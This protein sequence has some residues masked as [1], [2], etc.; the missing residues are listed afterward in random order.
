MAS[1]TKVI[2]TLNKHFVYRSDISKYY[3]VDY[4]LG[5]QSFREDVR[6]WEGDCEDYS[7]Y[8]YHNIENIKLWYCLLNNQG[9][10][11]SELPDGKWIDNNTKKPVDKLNSKQYSNFNQLSDKYIKDRLENDA[12]IDVDIQPIG[13]Y[14]LLNAIKNIPVKLWLE[15]KNIF[16]KIKSLFM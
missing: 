10:M 7:L 6:Y 8:L 16:N 1:Y 9:H 3:V 13:E 2:D 4:W 11:V 15:F 12:K 14:G 5:F